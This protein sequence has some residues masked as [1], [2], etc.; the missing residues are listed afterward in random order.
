MLITTS[1]IDN[2]VNLTGI[3]N[4]VVSDMSKVKCLQMLGRAR[5]SGPEDYKTL[6]VQR[7]GPDYVQKRIN[8]LQVQEDAYHDYDLAYNPP[9][10]PSQPSVS[11]E[12]RFL[13]KY[14]FPAERLGDLGRHLFGRNQKSTMQFADKEYYLNEIARSMIGTLISEYRAIYAEMVEEA[15]TGRIGQKYLEHQL[16][17]LGKTYCIDDDITFADK[18]KAKKDFVTFLEFYV[19]NREQIEGEE[20]MSTFQNLV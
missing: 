7:F 1:V 15:K 12:D 6:Y 18:E 14:I 11:A 5:V 8:V 13:D 20:S 9:S 3:K 16:S 10:C 2:G 19:K 4:V 17:W